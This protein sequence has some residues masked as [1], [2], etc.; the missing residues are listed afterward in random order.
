MIK[1]MSNTSALFLTFDHLNYCNREVKSPPAKESQFQ[2]LLVCP[3]R[4]S[5]HLTFNLI[6]GEE[7]ELTA[8]VKWTV[9]S[10]EL[11]I[12]LCSRNITDTKTEHCSE[13]CCNVHMQNYPEFLKQ[14]TKIKIKPN[15]PKK[16]LS[17]AL[18]F[19]VYEEVVCSQKNTYFKYFIHSCQ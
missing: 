7:G 4:P 14:E 19:R 15:T 5:L 10:S 3:Q 12:I 2:Q 18:V 16:Q 9:K 17:F 13:I 1:R 6:E 8:H 11:A